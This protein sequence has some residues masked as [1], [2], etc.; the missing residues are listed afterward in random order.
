MNHKL[1]N[2]HLESHPSSFAIASHLSGQILNPGSM[3]RS[4][5]WQGLWKATSFFPV[6][7]P[8]VT[9]GLKKGEITRSLRAQDCSIAI[10]TLP[11]LVPRI[12]MRCFLDLF[13]SVWIVLDLFGSFWIFLDLFGSFW[14][15]LDL[16]GFVW[17]FLDLSWIFLDLFG[18]F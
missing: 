6:S 14:I 9:V 12:S 5:W 18:S 16:L 11:H 13:G 7:T 8:P 4:S 17:I 1:L 2:L 10:I 15:F 3:L